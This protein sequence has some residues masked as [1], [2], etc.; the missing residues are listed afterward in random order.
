MPESRYDHIATDKASYQT[1]NIKVRALIR[2]LRRIRISFLELRQ[3][4]RV[5]FL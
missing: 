4:L 1:F 5:E 3:I 2:N